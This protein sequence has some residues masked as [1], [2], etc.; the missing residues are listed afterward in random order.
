METL[1]TQAAFKKQNKTWIANELP[2]TDKNIVNNLG[3]YIVCQ[4]YYY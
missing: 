2:Y 3:Y 4:Y 1:Y